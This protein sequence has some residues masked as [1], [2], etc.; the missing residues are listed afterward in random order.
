MREIMPKIGPDRGI[1][2]VEH[3]SS[4]KTTRIGSMSP[5]DG[6]YLGRGILACAAALCRPDPPQFGTILWDAHL[7]VLG[8]AVGSSVTNGEPLLIF[9]IPSGIELTFEM[10]RHAARE[11]ATA[12]VAHS[13][14]SAPITQGGRNH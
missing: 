9:T 3:Q 7:P 8:W 10:P 13:Y 11:I 12:L 14:G 4:G 6:A 5:E 1:E 2:I